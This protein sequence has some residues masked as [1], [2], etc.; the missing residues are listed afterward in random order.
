MLIFHPLEESRTYK[1]IPVMRATVG[2]GRGG[3]GREGEERG[4]EGRGGKEGRG[5]RGA[6]FKD[7]ITIQILHA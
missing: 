3:E 4:G 2:K 5:G 7:Q 6:N 1:I